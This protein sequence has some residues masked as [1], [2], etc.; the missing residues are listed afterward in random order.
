MSPESNRGGPKKF[1]FVMLHSGFTFYYDSAL[2]LLAERGH[3]ITVA[4]ERWVESKQL[5]RLAADFPNLTHL[6]LPKRKGDEWLGFSATL[7]SFWDFTRYLE[8][9]YRH[10]HYLRGR[11]E[12]VLD[13]AL[14]RHARRWAMA[15]RPGLRALAGAARALDRATPLNPQVVE[16]VKAQAPDAL[17]VTPLVNIGSTQVDYVRAAKQLGIRTGCGV[18]SWDNLTNKGLMRIIPDRVFVWNEMQRVEA[19]E[20]HGVPG[21]RVVVTGAQNF[22]HWFGWKPRSTRDEFC[23]RFGLDPAQPFFL[24]VGSTQSIAATEPDFVQRWIQEVRGSGRPE[25]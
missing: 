20:L 13:P 4:Y 24:F 2:R 22:D 23:R 15:G 9:R 10:A 7:R 5:E 21:D 1:L 18:A 25:L 11:V 6:R 16:F 19:V 14:V 12:A 3:T 17:L 8:P